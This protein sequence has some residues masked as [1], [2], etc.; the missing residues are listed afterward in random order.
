MDIVLLTKPGIAIDAAALAQSLVGLSASGSLPDPHFTHEFDD[1]EG[2]DATVSFDRP[3]LFCY[4]VE[5]AYYCTFEAALYSGVWYS[6][7]Q[8]FLEDAAARLAGK[9]APGVLRISSRSLGRNFYEVARWFLESVKVKHWALA[10]ALFHGRELTYQQVEDRLNC[11][12]RKLILEELAQ[13]RATWNNCAD[14]EVRQH[15]ATLL[16]D[17]VL[18][19]PCALTGGRRLPKYLVIYEDYLPAGVK[20]LN[21]VTKMRVTEIISNAPSC[22]TIEITDGA[23]SAYINN[24][25]GVA[26]DSAFSSIN[27]WPGEDLL[28]IWDHSRAFTTTYSSDCLPV[29]RLI[30]VLYNL[31]AS[32]DIVIGNVGTDLRSERYFSAYL[33]TPDVLQNEVFD[34][35]CQE[36]ESVFRELDKI[37]GTPLKAICIDYMQALDADG[38]TISISDPAT[39]AEIALLNAKLASRHLAQDI[40][41]ANEIVGAFC[42]HP[43]YQQEAYCLDYGLRIC[44]PYVEPFLKRLVVEPFDRFWMRDVPPEVTNEVVAKIIAVAPPIASDGTDDS[45]GS[46]LWASFHDVT[47]GWIRFLDDGVLCR[48]LSHRLLTRFAEAFPGIA[49]RRPDHEFLLKFADVVCR[50]GSKLGLH[51]AHCESTDDMLMATIPFGIEVGV[52]RPGDSRHAAFRRITIVYRLATG[53]WE[54][55]S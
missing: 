42:Y 52:L 27:N 49:C 46:S 29:S 19:H 31:L 17:I 45:L 37:I 15:D 38:R 24:L 53:N 12:D 25:P 50:M 11:I 20:G 34:D 18:Y 41:I 40:G 43:I 1:D 48:F 47:D 5:M 7:E 16:A 3:E 14:V 33:Q 10:P 22:L 21:E 39:R 9:E 23:R 26:G 8:K 32:K 30:M 2:W 36:N 13:E 6:S 44:A 51:A 4:D 28:E 55:T 54:L 35:R